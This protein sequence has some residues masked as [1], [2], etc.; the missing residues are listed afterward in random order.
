[1]LAACKLKLALIRVKYTP[2]D[3]SLH[4]WTAGRMKGRPQGLN[5]DAQLERSALERKIIGCVHWAERCLTWGALMS[6]CREFSANTV[7]RA[8]NDNQGQAR[9]SLRI[10]L[11]DVSQISK[12]FDMSL[13]LNSL[14]FRSVSEQPSTVHSW[15]NPVTYQTNENKNTAPQ[16]W[17]TS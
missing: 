5:A 13:V 10:E 3:C 9:S 1:M 7:W 11:A 16:T 15:K 14:P 8:V 17:N 12:P 2:I 4:S 6:A